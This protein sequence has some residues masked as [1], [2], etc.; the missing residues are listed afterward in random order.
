MKL[1]FRTGLMSENTLAMAERIE[2][3]AQEITDKSEQ[4]FQLLM[5]SFLRK[6]AV[7][8]KR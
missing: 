4:D 6:Y 5:V 7:L 2:A 1:H 3:S 8:R